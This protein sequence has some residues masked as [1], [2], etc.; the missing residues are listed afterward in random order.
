VGHPV[1]ANFTQHW[2]AHSLDRR[3]LYWKEV[4]DEMPVLPIGSD[5]GTLAAASVEKATIT[6]RYGED[7]RGEWMRE[8][9]SILRAG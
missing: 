2:Y 3:L 8:T 5:E 6:E 4:A 7:E 9:F 1:L